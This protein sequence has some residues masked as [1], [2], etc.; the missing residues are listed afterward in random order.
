MRMIRRSL[1]VLT[2]FVASAAIQSCVDAAG[3]S[4]IA[5]DVHSSAV[6]PATPQWFG[7]NF[8]SCTPM[9][10]DSVT[11]SVGSSGGTINVGPHQLIIPADALDSTVSITAVAPSDTINRLRLYPEGLEFEKKVSLKMSYANCAGISW[12]IPKRVTYVNSLL[13]ILD[14]LLSFDSWWTE[15]VTGKTDHF[16]DYVVAW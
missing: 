10:A 14:V 4:V 12:L 1:A 8:L 9:D 3:P 13:E 11:Q 7:L 6:P 16:S 2:A 15:T 5:P